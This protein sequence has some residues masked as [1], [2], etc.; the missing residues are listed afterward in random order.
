M[1]AKENIGTSDEITINYFGSNKSLSYEDRCEYIEK[2]G[3][4]CDCK[5]CEL[6]SMR[7]A[8]KNLNFHQLSLKETLDDV[9]LMEETY[10]KR[11]ELQHGLVNALQHLAC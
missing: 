4:K 2:Y 11:A 3:F 7:L 5:L 8:L 1:F 6:D 9:K 10:L